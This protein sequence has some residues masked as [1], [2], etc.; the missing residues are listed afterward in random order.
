MVVHIPDDIPNYKDWVDIKD[1]LIVKLHNHSNLTV[2]VI[3]APEGVKVW[4]NVSKVRVDDDVV[5]VILTEFKKQSMKIYSWRH[6]NDYTVFNLHEKKE[7]H[8]K[9]FGE[10]MRIATEILG[11][12][13]RIS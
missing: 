6:T 13:P 1:A 3:V 7:T 8:K 10:A 4:A 9:T 11:D 12:A 2:R 5:D